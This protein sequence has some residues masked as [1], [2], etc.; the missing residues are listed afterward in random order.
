MIA[1]MTGT[2]K[3]AT[4]AQQ[5]KLAELLTAERPSEWHHGDCTGADE[6]AFHI[7]KALGIV[8]VAHPA[9][10]VPLAKRANTPSDLRLPAKGA[11]K[12]NDD[13]V[14]AVEKLYALPGGYT[15][16][17]RSGT[18]ATVRRAIKAGVPVVTIWPDG[19][20]HPPQG[21]S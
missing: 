21:D 16:V 14:E 17:L 19:T 9:D 18:W 8:T 6:Q 12:R 10:D 5:R 7:A 20:C 1:G 2:Q 3:G 11:L 13:I 15:E 4:V